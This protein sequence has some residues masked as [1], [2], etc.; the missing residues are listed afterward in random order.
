MYEKELAAMIAAVKK[1]SAEIDRIYRSGFSVHLKSDHSPVTDADLASNAIIRKELS[2]FSD[3][4]WLSEEDADDFSRLSKRR[5]FVIDPLDGTQDFVNRDGSF[6]I[7]LALVEDHVPV[8]SVIGLPNQNTYAYAIAGSGAFY[9]DVAGIT[10]RMAVSSR[11]DHLILV[12]S[13][14]HDNPQETAVV[15]RYAS[16]IASVVRYGASEK[17]IRLARGEVDVSIRYTDQT[18]EWDVAA[19]DLLVRE[20]GGVFCDTKLQPFR[21]NRKDVY[22]HDGY[23]MFNRKENEFLLS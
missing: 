21:Y 12:L 10:T 1:A 3:I 19:P 2:V 11:T 16:K 20:A 4:S 7:N 8:V 5:L 13:K 22:N 17:A 23:C 14:T 15:T 18:K 6:S 9:V